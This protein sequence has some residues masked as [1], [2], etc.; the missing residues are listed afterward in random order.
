MR[1]AVYA[2]AA[3]ADVE[4]TRSTVDGATVVRVGPTS[5]TPDK[6]I[7]GEET[8]THPARRVGEHLPKLLGTVDV[9]ATR[10]REAFVDV[11][12]L[13]VGEDRGR[14]REVMLHNTVFIDVCEQRACVVVG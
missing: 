4:L 6:V 12:P 1:T 3:E 2:D 5:V 7:E 11:A 8:T 9:R 13:C 10:E 14:L